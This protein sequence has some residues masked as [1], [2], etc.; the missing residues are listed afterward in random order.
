MGE[1]FFYKN[2]ITLKNKEEDV[3]DELINYNLA[4]ENIEDLQYINRNK[5]NLEL[6]NV[7]ELI[8]LKD[9]SNYTFLL[10]YF[11]FNLLYHF[12]NGLRII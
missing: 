2:W 7:N 1:N 6:I 5:E 10:I 8:S 12:V 9:A 3:N 4:L 11:S